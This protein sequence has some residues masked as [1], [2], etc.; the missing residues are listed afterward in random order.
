M[1]EL[2]STER[3]LRDV[4]PRALRG[5][6]RAR[7]RATGATGTCCG[8]LGV[9]VR[10]RHGRP[11]RLRATA[12]SFGSRLYSAEER[13]ALPDAAELAS[14]GCGNPTAVAE[15]HEGET[16]LDLGSG[17]GI[18]VLL[19]PAASARPARPTAST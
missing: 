11:G 4:V 2:S 16:V 18:D 19:S 12:E 1:A 13:D 9:V 5:E 15:L 14:L 7:M 3:R 10:L 6:P 8:P 17:G